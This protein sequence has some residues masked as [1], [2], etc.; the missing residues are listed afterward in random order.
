MDLKPDQRFQ[1]AHLILQAM[2]QENLKLA[3]RGHLG[4]CLTTLLSIENC[5]QI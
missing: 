4:F 5:K 2:A 1:K 3:Y